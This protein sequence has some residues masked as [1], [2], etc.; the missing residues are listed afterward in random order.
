MTRKPAP[1]DL[2]VLVNHCQT[3]CGFGR[4]PCVREEMPCIQKLVVVKTMETN[5][6]HIHVKHS[7][8]SDP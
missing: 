1:D 6:F 7:E 5:S 4:C 3:R 2:L 8:G